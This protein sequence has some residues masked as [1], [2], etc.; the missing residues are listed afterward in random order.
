MLEAV[1]SLSG[2]EVW[3]ASNVDAALKLAMNG[4]DAIATDLAMPGMD[5]VE[6]IRLMRA[7]RMK[8]RVPIIAITGQAIEPTK[9]QAADL[10]CC[11]VVLKPCDV[12]AVGDLLHELIDTCVHDCDRCPARPSPAPQRR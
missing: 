5:G 1:L 4:V 2:F 8:P 9:I 12:S 10:D 6:F 7:G 3:S 11:R